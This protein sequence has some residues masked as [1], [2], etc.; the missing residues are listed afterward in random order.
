MLPMTDKLGSV[1][2]KQMVALVRG[3]KG[4]KQVIP[5]QAPK[6]PGPPAPLV[7]TAPTGDSFPS[8]DCASHG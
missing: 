4:G 6:A 3:F 8:G 1:D 5:L 7:V 2:V